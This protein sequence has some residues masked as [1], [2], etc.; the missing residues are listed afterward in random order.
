MSPVTSM[1]AITGLHSRAGSHLNTL[2]LAERRWL[3]LASSKA[4]FRTSWTA[5]AFGSSHFA[6]YVRLS[7]QLS[8]RCVVLARRAQCCSGFSILS[9]TSWFG[10]FLI[11]SHI[12]VS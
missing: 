10:P 5:F 2:S 9:F 1:R 6:S 4:T 3:Q 7:Y 12:C 11:L 8:P